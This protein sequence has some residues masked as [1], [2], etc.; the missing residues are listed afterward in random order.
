ML[1]ITDLQMVL[2]LWKIAD[3]FTA[4]NQEEIYSS[5]SELSHV[6]DCFVAYFE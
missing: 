6:D 5:E 2:A 1:K 3:G 4:F